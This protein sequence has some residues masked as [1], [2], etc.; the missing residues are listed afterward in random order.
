MSENMEQSPEMLLSPPIPSLPDDVTI[1]IVARVPRSH[2]PTLSLVS[3]SF[4]K[5]IASSKLYKRRSQLGITQRRLYAVLRNRK[6]GEFSFYVLH[7]K[8]NGYNRLVVVRSL[9]FMSS[10]GSC[11]S[12]GSKV[13]VF[14]DLS[15]LSFDCTSHTVQRGPN[16]PQRI[17][18]KEANVIGKKVYV[19]GDA[20]CH[21]VQG[22]G[23]MKVWQKAVTVFDTETESLEPKLVKEDMAVGVGPF[24]SDSVVLED[25]IYLKGYMNGNSFVY[26]PEERKWEL[27][28]EVLNSKD[29]EGACVV[30]GVLY[31]HDRSGKVLMAYDPKQG[32]W[33]VVNGLEEFL[34]VETARSRWSITVNYGAEKLALF[35]PKKQYGEKMICCA[36]I[37]LERRQG[38]E[39]WGKVQWCHVVIGDGS[40][41]MVKCVSVTV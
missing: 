16:F 24:W 14:N 41:D 18:Y 19:I 37:G 6:T 3:K 25:K 15:V 22:T 32:C 10:R 33:S 17:S 31:Y 21:Y 8:L 9:P 4:R 27:M 39:I 26:G 23:W 35:F 29:W 1:D 38:G 11:V 5:L 34:A 20:F 30:D 40:F 28:D 13:Y 2:Y 36:E 12:V 7:R